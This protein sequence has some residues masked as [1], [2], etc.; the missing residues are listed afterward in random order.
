MSDQFILH[1]DGGGNGSSIQCTL[2]SYTP[3]PE[4]VYHY[5]LGPQWMYGVVIGVVALA[6]VIAG[7]LIYQKIENPG[8][9]RAD[10]H[11]EERK[12]ELDAKARIA[13]AHN[14]CQNCGVIYAP[15]L[16]DI[17]T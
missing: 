12:A 10:R 1:C 9:S 4:T 15:K 16:E 6:I 8:T 13:E 14:S 2:S 3:P 7:M 5:A 11:L 17:E